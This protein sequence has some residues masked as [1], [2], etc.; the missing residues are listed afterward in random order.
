MSFIHDSTTVENLKFAENAPEEQKEEA[1]KK[2]L[3]QRDRTM[4]VLT[5]KYEFSS[6]EVESVLSDINGIGH[7]NLLSSQRIVYVEVE[8]GTES[9]QIKKIRALP[10]VTDV[11]RVAKGVSLR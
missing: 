9:D 6:Q 3:N 5:F 11:T 8:E 1:R 10:F 7:Y 4:M 2:F